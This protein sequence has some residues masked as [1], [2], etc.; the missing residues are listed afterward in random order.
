MS[1]WAWVVLALLIAAIACGRLDFEPI[2]RPKLDASGDGSPATSDG[3]NDA[4]MRKA[5]SMT[6]DC[7]TLRCG[8]SL[9]DPSYGE[10]CTQAID[11]TSLRCGCGKC[12]PMPG[13]CCTMP[14]D[15]ASLM[16][17]AGKCQ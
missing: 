7:P 3:G 1:S 16:C 6:T 15:C 5:C 11:C 17:V 8:C 13:D 4:A 14:V 10:C 2:H 12:D 9:C